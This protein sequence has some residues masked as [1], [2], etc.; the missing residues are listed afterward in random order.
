MNY[1]SPTFPL[2]PQS[3]PFVRNFLTYHQQAVQNCYNPRQ[4]TNA[5][6]I[7]TTL[8]ATGMRIALIEA[9]YHPNLQNDLD[10]FSDT[11][12][13]ARTTVT[14][15]GSL[16]QYSDPR[17]A[18]ETATDV[19]W[20]H[21]LAPDAKLE[22]YCAA[23]TKYPDLFQAVAAASSD[24]ADIIS[25]SFGSEEF[26][27]QQSYEEIFKSSDS[28][29]VC[30]SGDTGGQVFFP[31]SSP[32]VVSVGGTNLSIS[33]SGARLGQEIAWENSGGGPSMYNQIPAYQKIFGDLPSLS[34][35]MRATPDVSFFSAPRPG[36]AVY[37]TDK[38]NLSKWICVG[39]TSVAAPC[40][41]SI[42]ALSIA[43]GYSN[44]KSYPGFLYTLAGRT[45]YNKNQNSFHDITEG[46]NTV[47]EARVGYDLCTGL[48]TPKQIFNRNSAFG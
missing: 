31:S 22:V 7:D 19:Q 14:V 48:G 33:A 23:S 8:K 38:G 27:T 17:W 47:Y 4:I 24:G 29:F 20:A 15:K 26:T 36:Y 39:G 5:Y 10:V 46:N 6:G 37:F 42:I 11:F 9:F 41:A 44:K 16:E 21:A 43:N 32:Y 45:E 2:Y 13:L 1:N 40:I 34:G 25:M 28:V 35:N 3:E 30:A 18:I 12:S